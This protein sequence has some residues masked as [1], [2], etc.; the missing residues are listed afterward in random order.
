MAGGMDGEVKMG[1]WYWDHVLK[2]ESL[3]NWPLSFWVAVRITLS[4]WL[5]NLADVVAIRAKRG[6]SKT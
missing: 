4:R 1:W 3:I 5:R 2:G 6:V